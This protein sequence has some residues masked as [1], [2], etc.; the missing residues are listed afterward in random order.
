MFLVSSYRLS[1]VTMS[2]SVAVWPQF[3][4]WLRGT[5]RIYASQLWKN[6]SWSASWIKWLASG[7]IIRLHW[8]RSKH[9][10]NCCWTWTPRSKLR[11][12]WKIRSWFLHHSAAA[13]TVPYASQQSISLLY[14]F[15]TPGYIQMAAYRQHRHL[16]ISI[17]YASF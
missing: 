4:M 3:A 13:G 17:A 2:L 16:L 14:R 9:E 5:C 15:V 12:S 10:V 8:K 11:R 6:L 7:I 1:V